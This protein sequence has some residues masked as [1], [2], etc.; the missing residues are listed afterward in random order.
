MKG[1][2]LAGLVSLVSVCGRSAE[3]AASTSRFGSEWPPLPACLIYS[4]DTGAWGWERSL[5]RTQTEGKKG[6]IRFQGQKAYFLERGR[7]HVAWDESEL[8]FNEFW[9]TKQTVEPHAV[10]LGGLWRVEYRPPT[11]QER[12]AMGFEKNIAFKAWFLEMMFV[13]N[14]IPEAYVRYPALKD[15]RVNGRMLLVLNEFQP[16]LST[17]KAKPEFT[18]PAKL[19][20]VVIDSTMGEWLF[21]ESLASKRVLIMEHR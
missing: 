6:E 1:I 11:T 20:W 3:P 10:K 16:Y 7:F 19:I 14:E 12:I 8:I 2:F 17:P 15:V 9:R 4:D 5:S 18:T 13:E 21:P